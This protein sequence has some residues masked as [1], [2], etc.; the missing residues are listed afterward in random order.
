MT[1]IE[2]GATTVPAAPRGLFATLFD[3]A[4]LFPPGNVPMT[5]AV[6]D[7]CQ[8]RRSCPGTRI[9]ELPEA[10]AASLVVAGGPAAIDAAVRRAETRVRLAAME[11]SAIH[12]AATARDAVAALRAH[13]PDATAGFIE[14]P[15]GDARAAV[16][17]VLAGTGYHA[18]LRTGGTEAAT[19]PT[20]SELAD[21]IV[22]CLGRALAFKCT[23]G[24]HH[25]VRH[26]AAD[27]GFEH[28]GFLNVLAATAAADAG[29]DAGNVAR[30]LDERSS[31]ALCA[32]ICGLAH[33]EVLG[34]RRWFL[35]FGTCSVAEPLDD[36]LALGLV[37]P[38]RD[39]MTPAEPS[40]QHI[41]GPGPGSAETTRA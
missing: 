30:I 31:G 25:A 3:D 18:K 32:A 10:F 11:V 39:T 41:L 35:S 28:H 14:V 16:L 8:H 33:E 38:N 6:P 17:D 24:L 12:D 1:A 7:H 23:A 4:S 34:V 40:G 9:D 27:T 2:G 37:T 5:Q 21:A 20:A 29:A 26:T 19:F 36:L 15:R 22:G 13:L